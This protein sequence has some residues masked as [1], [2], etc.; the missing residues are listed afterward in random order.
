MGSRTQRYVGRP[1]LELLFGEETRKGSKVH[2]A[3]LRKAVIGHGYSLKKLRTISRFITLQSS[4]TSGDLIMHGTRPDPMPAPLNE[5]YS[6]PFYCITIFAIVT[7]P[8]AI[9]SEPM[10]V[11]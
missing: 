2:D 4:D 10:M 11:E 7:S 3:A 1:T 9:V 8:V 6:P 5:P